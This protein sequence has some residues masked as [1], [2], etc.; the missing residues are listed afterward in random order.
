MET[1]P[2]M[3]MS[4]ALVLI[5][6]DEKDLRTLLDFNLKRAGYRTVHA[7]NGREALQRAGSQRPD[8]ILLDLNLPDVSGTDVCQQLKADPATQG[9]PVVMLTAR[10]GE[11]DRITGFELG[12]DDY[13][14]KPFSVRELVL[15][16]D[17]V[18][19]RR[20]QTPTEPQKRLLK[21]GPI[22][23]D[24]EAFIV[25]V[26]GREVTLALLEYRLLCYLVEG[27][28]RVR[29]REELLRRVWEYPRDSDSRTIE[30]HVK[31]LRA[32]LGDAGEMIETVRSVGYR[33]RAE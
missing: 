4:G 30:T 3:D 31:R 32:K 33:I 11:A 8:L 20:R 17:A 5:V 29:T 9:I 12:A 24:T 13:V 26:D 23:I 6:D 21:A 18:L 28:G 7:A 2:L 19:R 14:P 15:R 1:V 25:R 22:E 10:S 27:A 16:V